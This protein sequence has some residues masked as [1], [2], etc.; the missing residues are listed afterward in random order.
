[1]SDYFLKYEYHIGARLNFDLG[2]N[3]YFFNDNYIIEKLHLMKDFIPESCPLDSLK[4]KELKSIL[5]NFDCPQ[6]LTTIGICDG[7]TSYIEIPRDNQVKR[8]GGHN[9]QNGDYLN[10]ERLIQSI[11]G[12]FIEKDIS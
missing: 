11:V 7:Y 5:E 2:Y 12:D 9:P 3:I 8:F 1:M 10:L 4:L 6:D